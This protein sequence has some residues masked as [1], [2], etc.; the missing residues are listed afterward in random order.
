MHSLVVGGLQDDDDD[1]D[2]DNDCNHDV[3]RVRWGDCDCNN[4]GCVLV[5]VMLVVFEQ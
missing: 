5:T 3:I 1:D 2:D 4:G